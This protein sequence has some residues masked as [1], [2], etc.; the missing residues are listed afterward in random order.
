MHIKNFLFQITSYELGYCAELHIHKKVMSIVNTLKEESIRSKERKEEWKHLSKPERALKQSE[1]MQRQVSLVN[2]LQALIPVYSDTVLAYIKVF[3][4]IAICVE[5]VSSLSL[6]VCSDGYNLLSPSLSLS[7]FLS[8]R[9]L[10]V[11]EIYIIHLIFHR[12]M[13][14]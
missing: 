2:E 9:V 4:A 1:M 7:L 5:A 14:R 8:R 6:C 10:H 3:Q 11:F 13:K 12:F